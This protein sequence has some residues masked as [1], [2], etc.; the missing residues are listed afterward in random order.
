MSIDVPAGMR[1]SV[2]IAATQ[3]YRSAEAEPEWPYGPNIAHRVPVC[4]LV[5]SL[6][7]R[8]LVAMGYEVQQEI[9]RGVEDINEHS[10]LLIDPAEMQIV[11]DAT[12][13]QFVPGEVW[14]PDLPKVLIGDRQDVVEQAKRRGV[15]E[16]WLT[17]WQE[18]PLKWA[19][20]VTRH[21]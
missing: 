4:G 8:Q 19:W 12:W 11:A 3:A 9:R 7:L 14:T 2:E 20:G 1:K 5:S 10:Y 13:Q 17:L 21:T 6:M 15:E 16:K 18:R